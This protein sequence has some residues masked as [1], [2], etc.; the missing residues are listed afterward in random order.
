MMKPLK[1]AHLA[2]GCETYMLACLAALLSLF[3]LSS[4][5]PLCLLNLLI[6]LRAQQLAAI[7]PHQYTVMYKAQHHYHHECSNI[8]SHAAT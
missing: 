5:L 6:Q 2:N 7:R 1:A 4:T 8:K 3:K